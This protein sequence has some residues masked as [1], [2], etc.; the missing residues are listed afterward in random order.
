MTGLADLAHLIDHER[1]RA[2]VPGCAVVV[3]RDG[4]VLLCRGFGHRDT[5]AS[6]PVTTR[7]LFPIGSATK[8]F[9]ASLVARLAVE[10]RLDLDAPMRDSWPEVGM[11]DP[12]AAAA[13]SLRDCLAH[14]S[15]LPRHDLLWLGT[16]GRV[17]RDDLVSALSHL[18]ASAPFRST[19]QYNNVLYIVAGH[20]VARS[21]GGSYEEVLEHDVL[22]PLRLERTTFSSAQA[23]G[24]AD[25]ALPYDRD[26]RELAFVPLD[27]AGPAGGLISCADDLALWLLALTAAGPALDVMRTPCIARPTPDPQ[28]PFSETA[29]GLG[30]MLES[31][32][33]QVVSHHGGNIDGYSAQVLTREDGTGIA[34]LTNLHATAF[35]DSL[36]YQVLDLLDGV[37]PSAPD[38]ASFFADRLGRTLAPLNERRATHAEGIPAQGLVGRYRHP[39]YGEVTVTATDAGLRWSYQGVPQGDLD[40]RPDGSVEAHYQFFGVEL[41]ATGAATPTELRLQLEPAVD[42]LVFRRC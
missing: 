14:R 25:R 40:A 17:D 19:Y 4:E 8:T 33:G 23:L 34:V 3:V 7:T 42:P 24:D 36:P 6:A 28:G 16:G 5:A 32:R 2:G 27:L 11:L 10:G 26:G 13:L 21:L 12:D 22:S 30:L 29:Y 31:Y 15:G 9:T 18:P 20:L 38:H 1:V 37:V 35:R 39:G 41:A